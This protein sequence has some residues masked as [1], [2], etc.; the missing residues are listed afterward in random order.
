MS[1]KLTFYDLVENG[2]DLGLLVVRRIGRPD[3]EVEPA[4][5][6]ILIRVIS[7]IPVED[8]IVSV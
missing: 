8:D 4:D 5:R 2:Y 1:K 3:L 7:I 6:H